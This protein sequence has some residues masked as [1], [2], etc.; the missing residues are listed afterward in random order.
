MR[1]NKER[2]DSNKV[3]SVSE[4]YGIDLLTAA[5]LC[6]RDLTDPNDVRYVLEDDVRYMHNP[7]LFD[8]MEDAVDRILQAASEGE[9]VL[10]F[11]DRDVD[12][13]TSTT[14]L[15]RTFREL[16]INVDWAVPM[17]DEPYSIQVGTIDR[18]HEQDGTLIVTVDCGITAVSAIEHAQSLGIDTVIVDHHNAPELLPPA[19]AIINPK[20]SDSSYPFDGLC[21]CGLAAKLRWALIF[22]QGELYKQPVVLLNARPGNETVII[23]AVRLINLVEVDRVSE[24]LVPGVGNIEQTRLF[25]FL[26]GNAILVYDETTQAKLIRKAFG[27]SVDVHVLD[28]ATEIHRY[29]PSLQGKS[30]IRMRDQSR[31]AV[32]ST[33]SPSELDVLVQ[34]YTIFLT[35][36]EPRLGASY[37]ERL[38]LPALGTLADMM[39]LIDENRIIVRQGLR[40]LAT[41]RNPGLRELLARLGLAGRTL[42]SNDVAWQISPVINAS[43]RMGEP[44]KAVRLFLSDDPA[45]CATLAESIVQLNLTRKKIG[46]TAWTRILP[47]AQQSYE[48]SGGRFVLVRDDD[49][50]RGI[51]GIIAGR[52]ARLFNAPATVVAVV[53]KRA[54]GSV[55][56]MRGFG[57]TGF[58]AQLDDILDD[59][60]GHD[61][62]GGFHLQ[63]E[64]WT[65][66]ERRIA[67]LVPDIVLTEE[68]EPS[69][70]IDAEL[71]HAHLNP[72]L[73]SLV[74]RLGPYGQQYRGLLFMSSGLRILD[75]QLVGKGEKKH[76][77]L[78]L[79]S[80]KHKW[81]ALFWNAGE[82]LD[83]DFA[84][85]DVVDA[86]F[87][88]TVNHY[89]GNETLQL[90]LQDVRRS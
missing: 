63:L 52:L 22:A 43:G 40:A 69:V 5:I 36:K 62:A 57:V 16:G 90:V 39:P 73:R 53:D 78:L 79:D 72:E 81:P 28:I 25:S 27:P 83:A 37:A 67:E 8:E 26:Q 30:L 4:R 21:G 87:E 84:T 34:L 12:G 41:T 68:L 82:R 76:A 31:M 86:V 18:F 89:Q 66:F 44:D 61:A 15:V 50:H 56:A 1:W 49:V 20:I 51:T 59:W 11:G 33:E 48:A 75:A 24:N 71:P 10:V 47:A 2:I 19:V 7:F 60:G 46:E 6:R 74:E 65:E 35:A 77:K 23:E 32:Y 42:S 55:R 70:T 13:I 88:V 80:G 54:V 58:L 3:R 45:E 9:K 85:G 38:D 64:R 29:F 14:L 17:G